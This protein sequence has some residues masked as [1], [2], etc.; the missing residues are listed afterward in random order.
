MLLIEWHCFIEWVN[1]REGRKRLILRIEKRNDCFERLIECVVYE[2]RMSGHGWLLLRR[3]IDDDLYDRY[4]WVECVFVFSSTMRERERLNEDW[5]KSYWN[6]YQL[7]LTNEWVIENCFQILTAKPFFFF[8]KLFLS[9][10]LTSTPLHPP[11]SSFHTESSISLSCCPPPWLW[12]WLCW[13][14]LLFVEM[15]HKHFV[16]LF[17]VFVHWTRLVSLPHVVGVITM[18]LPSLLHPVQPGIVLFMAWHR[19][20]GLFWLNCL[21][22]VSFLFC[23]F[24]LMI[25]IVFLHSSFSGVLISK[26]FLF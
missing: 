6:D 7:E 10:F 21:W 23:S 5:L 13:W 1:E 15:T 24:S 9:L 8:W 19:P 17:Q 12:E 20:Q 14:W 3:W 25:A 2:M 22:F 18:V 4:W 26:N 16:T 11:T